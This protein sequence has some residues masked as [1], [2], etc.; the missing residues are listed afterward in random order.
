MRERIGKVFILQN[1]DYSVVGTGFLMRK[2]PLFQFFDVDLFYRDKVLQPRL[3]N[4]PFFTQQPRTFELLPSPLLNRQ[5]HQK[6]AT[7]VVSPPPGTLLSVRGS[8]S[9]PKICAFR[10]HCRRPTPSKPPQLKAASFFRCGLQWLTVC[11]QPFA[12]AVVR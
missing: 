11:Q 12:A 8:C 10:R 9:G 7:M 5:K 1:Y 6:R 2:C 4:S 3:T